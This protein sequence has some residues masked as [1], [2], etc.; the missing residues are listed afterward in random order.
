[1]K[2]FLTSLLAFSV[3]TAS[4]QTSPTR[5]PLRVFATFEDMVADKP[6]EGVNAEAHSAAL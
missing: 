6:V 3:L 5:T 2:L 1:M 4:A